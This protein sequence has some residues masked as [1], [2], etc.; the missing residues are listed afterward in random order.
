MRRFAAP[1][2]L[3]ALC[4]LIAGCGGH[5]DKSSSALDDALGYFSKDAPFVAAVE[6]D[7][8][9]PQLRQ[10]K[11]LTGSFP[12]TA[13]LA[14]RLQGLTRFQ[15]VQWD[16]DVRPQI[17]APLVVGLF[18]PAA[19]SG[20]PT[21]L[22]VAMRVKHPLLAK[23]TLLRDPGF[24]GSSKSSGARIY[25]N[26]TA[27]RYVAVDGDTVVAG[28]DRGILEQALAIKRSPNRMHASGFQSDLKGLPGGGLVRISAD[29][30]ALIGVDARLRPALNV[31]WLA[32]LR[33]FGAVAKATPSGI[34]F[35]FHAATDPSTLRKADLPLGPAIGSFPLI[36]K[37][38][39]L[40]LGVSEP[41]R[42]VRLAFQIANAIAPKRMALLRAL[43]P[44]GVDLQRQLPHHL[45]KVAQL[46]ADPLTKRFALRAPLNESADVRAALGQLA[47]ALPGVAAL[48]GM[49]GLGV[50]T[51]EPGES[52]YALAKPNGHTVVF[53]VVGDSLVAASEAKRAAGLIS[54]PTHPA[55]GAGKGAL[56]FT[57]N[58]RELAGKL[59]A[60]QLGGPAGLF[61]P[62]AVVGLRDL[63]GTVTNDRSGLDGHLQL[64]IVR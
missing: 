30:R 26:T 41:G 4:L 60:Q 35:D 28:T 24:R 59:L 51:P 34:T 5:G 8:N 33:R 31:K 55:V 54:E 38:G 10:L 61:A 3:V 21:A 15:N 39:E 22:V 44:H 58:A 6:T 9:G 56:V 49:P 42:L 29:P 64:T 48:F 57:V 40:Q 52:F 53:G 47:P 32:A 43:E 36:G 37:R 62:L 7:P 13:L 19:G 20:I 17:G 63:T 1:T 16:R 27:Q 45:A 18:R 50:A 12:A 2:A 25:E 11:A 14:T 46:S 23:Q